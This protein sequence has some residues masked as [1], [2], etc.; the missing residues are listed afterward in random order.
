M[1]NNLAK[2]KEL[3]KSGNY[4]CVVTNGK[5]VFTSTD[6]GVKP[7]L[8]WFDDGE[9]F[10]DFVVADKVV[11]KAAAYIY[12]LLKVS[13]VYADVM[14]KKATEVFEK[15][16][17]DYS[18]GVLVDAIRNRTNT[19]YCPMEQAVADISSPSDAITAIKETLNKL[20]TN[21]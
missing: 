10:A 20:I 18:G 12:V 2:A 1:K 11:G 5:D 16:G 6:R 7:L 21:N 17:V 15:W 13:Y 8:S 14:S 4:T 19:G 9:D 3:L